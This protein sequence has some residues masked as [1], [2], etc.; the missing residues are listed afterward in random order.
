M[1][2]QKTKL[3]VK[4]PFCGKEQEIEVSTKG[5]EEYRNG[6]LIQHAFPELDADT[7]ELI[8]TGICNDCFPHDDSED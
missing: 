6:T 5:L 2:G 1:D 8:M 3:T 4:C 7:R